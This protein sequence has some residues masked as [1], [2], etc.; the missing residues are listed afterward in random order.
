MNRLIAPTLAFVAAHIVFVGGAL[1]LA[2][3][4]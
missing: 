4:S 2:L 1:T 3:L